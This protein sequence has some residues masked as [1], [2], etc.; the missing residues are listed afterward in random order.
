[1]VKEVLSSDGPEVRLL[2]MASGSSIYTAGPTDGYGACTI[3]QQYAAKVTV[4]MVTSVSNPDVTDL[5]RDIIK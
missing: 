4:L 2:K 3:C 5:L 1:L